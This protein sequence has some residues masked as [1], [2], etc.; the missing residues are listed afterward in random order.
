MASTKQASQKEAMDARRTRRQSAGA[1]REH[2]DK[3]FSAQE[4]RQECE[5]T[6]SV[7]NSRTFSLFIYAN[8]GRWS[9]ARPTGPPRPRHGKIHR[10]NFWPPQTMSGETAHSV[11]AWFPPRAEHREVAYAPTLCQWP[12]A[13]HIV[14]QMGCRN[15]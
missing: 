10:S 1:G 13:V 7:T 12:Y 15:G 8:R 11:D 14:R 2:D 4:R 9:G 5:E 6:V 3:K